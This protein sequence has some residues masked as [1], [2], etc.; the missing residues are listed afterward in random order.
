MEFLRTLGAWLGSF[1]D[2]FLHLDKHLDTAIGSFGSAT[3][4]LLFLIVFLE[5]GL[6]VTP[7]LPGD[8]LLFAAGAFAARGAL[9][10][11]LLLVLLV[12]AA[13]GG[14]ALNYAIGYYLG[15]RLLKSENRF[16]KKAYLDKT[17]EFY[18]RYGGKTIVLARF[19]PIVRTFA[20]FMAGLA[21]MNYWT[22]FVYNVAG[23]VFWVSACTVAGYFFGGL[24]MVKDNFTLV[25]LGI[26]FVSILPALIEILRARTQRA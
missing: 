13:V 8:S 3:Y 22:F 15:E 20:P 9:D 26:V 16:F 7:L 2:L 4:A 19:V 23:A 6:V 17:K 12:V 14:D 5:T 21:K 25:V 10:L 11:S 18:E 1:V 24:A